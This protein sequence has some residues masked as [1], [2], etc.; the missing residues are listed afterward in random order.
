MLTG[1]QHEAVML[2]SREVVR[3]RIFRI[4]RFHY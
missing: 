3:K 4:S 2:F 1:E